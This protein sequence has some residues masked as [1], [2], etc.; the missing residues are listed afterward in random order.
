MKIAIIEDD[1]DMIECVSRYLDFQWP[2]A[3]IVSAKQGLDGVDM[4]KREAPDIIILDVGL[5][6]ID[7]FEVCRRIRL[8]SK[9]PVVM[10]TARDEEADKIEG[11]DVGADD[12]I[13]KPFGR[14]ELIARMKAVLRRFESMADLEQSRDILIAGKVNIDFAAHEVFV[15]GEEVKLTPI[16]YNLLYLLAKNRGQTVANRVILDRVWGTTDHTDAMDCLKVY[17]QRLRV[18]LGDNPQ[19]PKLFISDRDEGYQLANLC[20]EGN[21]SLKNL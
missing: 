2:E 8:F 16:E 17:I 21:L 1:P 12:Y 11:L 18:K 4:V 13:T 14:A 9:M 19:N 10:L 3:K 6:D 15:D 7:G 20:E 5:P